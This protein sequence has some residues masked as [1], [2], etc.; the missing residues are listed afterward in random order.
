MISPKSLRIM[1]LKW[2][3][4]LL[5]GICIGGIVVSS[6][7]Y[8]LMLPERVGIEHVAV[9][10]LSGTISYS[11]SPLTL[12]SG[13]TITPD[14]V[15]ELIDEVEADPY[16]KAVVIVI[17]S[18]GGSAAASEEI[19]QM[20][21]KLSQERVVVA[22]IAEYGASGGYYISLP[23]DRIIASPH[24]LTGS[25][26]AVSLVINFAELMDKLGIR[27]ET[28]KSGRLKDIGSAWRPLTEEERRILQSMVD[29][30]ARVFEER[31]EENRGDKIRDWDEILTARPFIGMQALKLGLIDDIGNL[32]DAIDAA[33]ALAGLPETAPVKWIKPRKPSLLELLLGGGESKAMKLSYE[34]LLMWPLPTGIEPDQLITAGTCQLIKD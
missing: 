22:Y 27:A 28:F 13:E 12:F 30:I 25:I 18:P 19:Y 26:G 6:V 5:I 1:A 2:W 14:R 11:E 34:I 20:I 23:A 33:R 24:A 16:A 9:I 32:E 7:A 17:N 4:W 29:S 21:K 10:Q 31:V 15:R 8:F 3:V